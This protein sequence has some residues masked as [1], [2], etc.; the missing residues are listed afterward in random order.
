MAKKK[1]NIYGSSLRE[2][3]RRS[4]KTFEELEETFKW[5]KSSL[6]G[7][8]KGISYPYDFDRVITLAQYLETDPDEMLAGL[9]ADRQEIILKVDPSNR[10]QLE[11]AIQLVRFWYSSGSRKIPELRKFLSK[12]NESTHSETGV[13]GKKKRLRAVR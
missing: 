1:P 11:T 9:I 5:S 10:S 6:L 13:N 3:R 2:A 7:H 12:S 8:E 4:G